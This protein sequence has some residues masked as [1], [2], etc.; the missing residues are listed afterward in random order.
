MVTSLPIWSMEYGP[1]VGTHNCVFS[2][3]ALSLYYC[4]VS[5]LLH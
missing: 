3:I 2:V 5:E 4:D 1:V